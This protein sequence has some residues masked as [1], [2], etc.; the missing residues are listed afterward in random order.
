MFDRNDLRAAVSADIL[1]ADQAARLEAFLNS[2]HAAG[3]D[4]GQET[5]R[6]LSNFNDIFVTIGIAI[7]FIGITALSGMM[8]GPAASVSN[9]SALLLVFAPV[10]LAA[11][12]MLEYFC[13]RRRM[14]LPSMALSVI[15]V[16]SVATG[17][18]GVFAEILGSDVA[19]FW[20]AF[21]AAGAVG[22][23]TFAGALAASL[24]VFW[25]YRLPFS[26]LLAALS[27]TGIAYAGA[28]SLGETGAIFGGGLS[29]LMGLGTFA[30]AIWFDMRDPERVRRASDHAFWL[31]AAAAPQ[32]I[33]GISAISTGSNMFAGATLGADN[34]LQG[35]VLL[36]TLVLMG[37]IALALNRRALIAASLLTF[38]WT[39]G[40]VLN[41]AGMDGLGVFMTVTMV[42]GGGVVL[43]GAGW[44]TARRAAL[45][46]FPRGGVW[47]RLFPPEIA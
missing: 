25:R 47:D 38:I 28:A 10:A 30:A 17:F 22:M 9:P 32:L 26:L 24:F 33:L 19:G 40:F 11:F 1:S 21:Q 46:V 6:F 15:F 44:K 8:F 37:L 43:L 18:V 2:R 5:L 34:A 39:L 36:V 29:L 31:H 4:A 16:T 7:L 3:D 41:E 13:A 12:G 20:D 27:A 45:K 14:L 23:A 42:V 35:M